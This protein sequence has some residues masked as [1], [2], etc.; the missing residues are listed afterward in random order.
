MPFVD[1]LHFRGNLVD[2][3]TIYQCDPFPL[4]E[5]RAPYAERTELDATPELP[6]RI[7]A[8]GSE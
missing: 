4:S 5:A 1:I 3:E 7:K 2:R 8:A 6:M